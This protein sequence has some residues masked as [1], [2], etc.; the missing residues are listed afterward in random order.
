MQMYALGVIPL[1]DRLRPV[2]SDPSGPGVQVWYADDS[3]AAGRLRALRRWLDLIAREGPA[4]GYHCNSAKTYLVVKPALLD[5]ARA[6]F[7]GTG[8]NIVAGA[9]RDLGAAIGALPETQNYVREK[10]E[11][12]IQRVEGLARVAAV[13]PHAAY[14]AY[15]AALSHTWTFTQ[16]TMSGISHLFAPLRDTI[17]R[18]LVPALFDNKL[19]GVEF[20]DD[21]LDLVGLPHRHGTRWHDAIADLV[22]EC[23]LKHSDHR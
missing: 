18:K 2:M 14:A 20:G 5:D 4:Y 19:K 9:H 17:Q 1:I 21:F 15:V 3:Q 8:V 16:R 11:K 7:E 13:H 6:I 12:W 23:G 22:V 10:V